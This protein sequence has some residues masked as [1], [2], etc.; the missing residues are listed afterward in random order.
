[1]SGSRPGRGTPCPRQAAFQSLGSTGSPRS[2]RTAAPASSSVGET[3]RATR[4]PRIACVGLVD[5]RQIKSRFHIL[6]EIRL[7]F[8]LHQV[9]NRRRQKVHLIRFIGSKRFFV[10]H[11]FILPNA[12]LMESDLLDRLF[13]TEILALTK[14]ILDAT[15]CK[16]ECAGYSNILPGGGTRFWEAQGHFKPVS[17]LDVGN[18]GQYN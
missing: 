11:A 17:R 12:P 16:V 5:F 18:F 14:L 7:V 8:F 15:R 9:I 4:L 3:A 1:M 10:V 6:H 13:S 2:S